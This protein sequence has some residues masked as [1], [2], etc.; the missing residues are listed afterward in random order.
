MCESAVVIDGDLTSYCAVILA[1]GRAS[2]LGGTDKAS[3]ELHGRTMLDRAL[4][5]V[6]DAA[7]VVVVGEQVPTERPVTFVIED[8]AYGGPVAAL[9]T[10]RDH[11]LRTCPIVVVLAV[12][13]PFVTSSTLRR[14]QLAAVGHDGAVLTDP[15]GRRQLALLL[16]LSR[17]DVVQPEREARHDAALRDLLAP[18]DLVEVAPVGFE[19]RDVDSW[20][21]LR[22]I[23]EL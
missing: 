11:L 6:V 4:D 10:G 2:R 18:L 12:D 22:D 7:E 17:L 19:H 5:A 15:E 23:S 14:L 16:D 20:S 8:P 21:D 9:L 13:M 3:I 1:R